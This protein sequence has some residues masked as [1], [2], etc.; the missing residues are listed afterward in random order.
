M[1][2]KLLS[3]W[4]LRA[5]EEIMLTTVGA[6]YRVCI[7]PCSSTTHSLINFLQTISKSSAVTLLEGQTVL[8]CRLT[9]TKIFVPEYLP[10]PDSVPLFDLVGF[11]GRAAIGDADPN[12]TGVVLFLTAGSDTAVTSM[13]KQDNPGLLFLD[14]PEDVLSKPLES[15][16]TARVICL[17]SEPETYFGVRKNGVKGTIVHMPDECGG[18]SWSR[19]VSLEPSQDQAVPTEIAMKNPTS[20]VYNFSFDYK[21]RNARRDAGTISIRMDYS[22]VAGMYY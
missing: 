16:Q 13:K 15:I 4:I 21:I 10:P 14:C 9:W 12:Q 18:G 1:M 5:V 17:H 11:N 6:L 22:N 2:I 20:A 8:F 19:A 7:M 3:I